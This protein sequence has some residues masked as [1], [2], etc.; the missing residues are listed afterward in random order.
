MDTI[1][2]TFFSWATLATMAG[3]VAATVAITQLLKGVSFI[4]KLPT[5]VFAYIVALVILLGATYFTGDLSIEAGG[6]CL[7]NAVVVALAANGAYDAY[8]S[9]KKTE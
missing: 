3:A 7:I 8:A 2:T 4:D 9:T 6:L 5:R 1:T